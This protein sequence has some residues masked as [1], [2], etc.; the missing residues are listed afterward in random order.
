MLQASEHAL[1]NHYLRPVTH[2]LAETI[3]RPVLTIAAMTVGAF[4]LSGCGTPTPA[5]GL[6]SQS[7]SNDH[8]TTAGGFGLG[9]EQFNTNGGAFGPD[10]TGH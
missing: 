5:P 9:P 2:S 1:G 3:M 10:T 8:T 6:Q 7:Y 4:L